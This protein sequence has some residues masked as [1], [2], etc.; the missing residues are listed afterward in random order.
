MGLYRVLE[1]WPD[2][3]V[4]FRLQRSRARIKW[5]PCTLNLDS[6]WPYLSPARGRRGSVQLTDQNRRDLCTTLIFK[7][8]LEHVPIR[9]QYS[10]RIRPPR[11][12]DTFSEIRR[13]PSESSVKK[14]PTHRRGS[15]LCGRHRVVCYT[16]ALVFDSPRL[17]LSLPKVQP[18][19]ASRLLFFS[20]AGLADWHQPKH[21][22]C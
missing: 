7:W 11:H 2:K 6:S 14:G 15:Y 16:F 1:V 18:A 19:K 20:Q 9:F 12:S 21:G 13:E 17:T 4:L 10:T 22:P 5:P 3:A 8:Q